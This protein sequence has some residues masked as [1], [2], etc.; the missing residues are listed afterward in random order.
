MAKKLFEIEWDDSLGSE[1]ISKYNLESC[2]FGKK[3]TDPQRV[4]TKEITT[5]E[6]LKMVVKRFKD[7]PDFR[8]ELKRMA[9]EV[10]KKK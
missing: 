5:E 6:L 9:K 7:E 10:M 3:H 1:W 8:F 4:T 2:L